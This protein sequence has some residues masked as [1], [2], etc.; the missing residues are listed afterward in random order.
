[1]EYLY[2]IRDGQDGSASVEFFDCE[3]T[4]ILAEV[5]DEEAYGLGEGGSILEVDGSLLEDLTTEMDL[6]ERHGQE[7]VDKAIIDGDWRL[8]EIDN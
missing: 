1:M 7:A 8:Q 5:I 6:V 2:N 4:M 3:R